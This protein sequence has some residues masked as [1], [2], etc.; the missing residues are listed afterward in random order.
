[1]NKRPCIITY[2]MKLYS[3]YTTTHYSS[4]KSFANMCSSKQSHIVHV[5]IFLVREVCIVYALMSVCSYKSVSNILLV[6]KPSHHFFPGETLLAGCAGCDEEGKSQRS[7]G[8]TLSGWE[9]ATGVLQGIC[10]ACEW[11][12]SCVASEQLLV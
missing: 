10:D 3:G 1:M 12:A 6:L 5:R 7:N 9:G 8:G 2:N 4:S 11:V